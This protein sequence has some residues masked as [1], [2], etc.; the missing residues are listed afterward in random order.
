M[1]AYTPGWLLWAHPRPQLTAPAKTNVPFSR[2]TS[3]PPLSP[4]QLSILPCLYPAQSMRDVTRPPLYILVHSPRS[5]I[6]TWATRSLSDPEPDSRMLPHPVTKHR[7]SAGKLRPDC[8][9]QMG[10]I[11]SL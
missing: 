1:L 5:I 3:G 7:V 11:A 8:G 9:R 4:W 2:Q 10:L 6:G